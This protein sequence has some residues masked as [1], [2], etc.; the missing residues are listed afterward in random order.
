MLCISQAAFCDDVQKSINTNYLRTPEASAFK[1]YGEESVNEYTGTA[2]ISVPLYTIKN[3]DIEIPLVLRYDASGIKVEQDASWVGLGWNLMVGGCINYVCAGDHDIQKA[4]NIPT[5]TWTEYLTSDF[6]PWNSGSAIGGGIQNMGQNQPAYRSRTKYYTYDANDTF[7]WMN[8]RPYQAHR[9]VESY[10]D[11]FSESWGMRGYL[12]WGYGERDFYSVNVMGKSFMFFV[13]PAT[14]NVFNIGKASEEFVVTPDFS[15]NDTEPGIGNIPDVGTW[16]I[17][18]SS[19]YNYYFAVSDKCQMDKKSGMTYTTCWYLTKIQS[20]LGETVEFQ[21]AELNRNARQSLVES[22]KIPIFH[23]GGAFCCH[24][25]SNQDYVRYLQNENANMGTTT[26]YL[27]KIITGKQTVA[28]TTSNSDQSSGKKLD[29]IKIYYNG[30]LKRTFNMSFGSFG[31]SNIGGNYAQNDPSLTSQNRLKLNNVK[32][33]ASKDTLVT[34]FSYNEAVKLP[35]K[36]SCAQDYW[37]YYN[38]KENKTNRG[39]TLVPAPG[40]FM[41]SNYIE[42]LKTYEKTGANRYCDSKFMQAAIL[43]KVTYPTGGCTKYEYEPNSYEINDYKLSLE[44]EEYLNRGYDIN[45]NKYF[46]YTPDAPVKVSNTPYNFTLTGDLNYSLS[47]GCSG[48]AIN[49]STFSVV[50]VSLSTGG[51]PT[52]IPVKYK[53][54]ND[55]IEIKTGTL[56]AGNYQL[57]IGAPSTGTKNYGISCLLKGNYASNSF[58]KL[59]PQKTFS[60]MVGGL[61]IAKISNYDNNGTQIDYTTYKY[62]GGVLLNN[63]ETID[64]QEMYNFRPEATQTTYAGQTYSIKYYTITSGH[65]RMPAFFASCNPGIVGYSTV[66]KCKYSAIGGSKLEKKIVSTYQNLGPT[67]E[68]G[69]DYYY[70]FDNGQLLTQEIYNGNTIIAK[71]T[72]D[73]SNEIVDHYATNIVGKLKSLNGVSAISPVYKENQTIY[74]RNG[75]GTTSKIENWPVGN[76]YENVFDVLRYPYILSRNVLERTINTETC[77]G[78]QTI[79]TTKKYSYNEKNHQVSQIDEF[80]SDNVKNARNDI[81]LTNNINRT[82]IKYTVDEVNSDSKCKTMVQSYHRLNDVVENKKLIVENGTEKCISTE[83]IAYNGG[84]YSVPISSSTSIGNATVEKRAEY[85]YDG[86]RNIRSIKID[87]FETVYIWSYSGQYPIAK[88]EGVT[89][90]DVINTM[91]GTISS[92]FPT[93][94][95][96]EDMGT[97][98][99]DK[100]TDENDPTKILAHIN[101]IRKRVDGIGGYVTTYTYSPL[102]GMTSQT[103]PNGLKT[104]Y[105]Y[106]GFGR[107][108][109]VLDHNGKV[110]STNEYNY[111]K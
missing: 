94:T 30:T 10:K 57:I 103:L 108:I 67:N 65:P 73:Y 55:L 83:R 77:S 45:I 79:I 109:K 9:F 91:A 47:V 98:A 87:G 29:A 62:D 27:S 43:N 25:L 58:E 51:T 106:D 44:Y 28:F 74:N 37:G 111:K 110:I 100:I 42:D 95:K 17:T 46:S 78:S 7:N 22:R 63:I 86:R 16:K 99:L 88:I 52:E 69:M 32:E 97:V 70:R 84:T 41:S 6:T 21:Y 81:S 72:N 36:R 61:R 11:I 4:P 105:Q 104:T 64:Y 53:S 96:I 50:I 8:K 48:D 56:H 5:K 23:N 18:D 12:D 68:Y 39:Y 102:V 60:R 13:D 31:Y 2:D 90:N 34:S 19:G 14:L 80:R 49:G 33:I 101:E 71:I 38:G 107:L 3:K 59:Y 76:S 20:P 15:R 26:H 1:K 92:Q 82:K 93:G 75:I 66:T 35:S 40:K 85:K 54:S 24:S 89:L